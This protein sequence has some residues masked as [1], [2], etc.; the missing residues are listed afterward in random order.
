MARRK[1]GA[2]VSVKITSARHIHRG[3]AVAV[4]TTLENISPARAA[5]MEQAG[6]GYVVKSGGPSLDTQAE[7]AKVAAAAELD[8]GDNPAGGDEDG[9]SGDEEPAARSPGGQ[10]GEDGLTAKGG[11]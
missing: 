11:A 5:F 7:A 1:Q 9:D 6:A 8:A 10:A 3:L 4:G 2:G